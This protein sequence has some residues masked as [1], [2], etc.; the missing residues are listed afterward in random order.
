MVLVEV[1]IQLR[2]RRFLITGC[3]KALEDYAVNLFSSYCCSNSMVL[4]ILAA[5]VQ[6][7]LTRP[8]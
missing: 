6:I 4:Y 5:P 1:K 2:S 8:R 7:S 3:R